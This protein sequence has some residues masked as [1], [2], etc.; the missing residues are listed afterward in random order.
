MAG[1]PS[2]GN[3]STKL[4]RIAKLTKQMPGVA[5][6]TLA[7]H[8]DLEWLHE[9]YRR[10]RKDGA[11]GVDGQTAA[12]YAANLQANL[13]TLLDRAKSGDNYRAPPVRR[14]Y[15]PKGDGDK[16]RPIGMPAFEDKV[17][18]RAI[19]MVLEA[20]YEQQ[21]LDCSYGFRPKRSAHQA[22]R[23]VW[24]QAMDLGG[25]WVLEAD[26]EDFFDSISHDLVERAVAHHTEVPWVRLY[27]ARW[28]RA[29]MQRPDGT[30]E[31]RT[32]GTPQGG[33]VSPL[34]ANLFLH[35]AFDMWMRR[36]FPSVAFERFADDTVVH[37]RSEKQART[38]L[39][40]IRGRF[41]ECGLELHPMKTRI[42]YCKDDDRR[43]EFE[44]VAFDFLGYLPTST[45]EDSLR[46]VLRE[47]SAGDQYQG[48]QEDPRD[49]P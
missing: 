24:K 38:V 16:T 40:A 41:L 48:S 22:L 43:G 1:T 11:V 28:L 30:L 4:E 2:S 23:A 21:F 26:I 34:L 6:T 49:H 46:K 9:A 29:P 7:H 45:R 14:V 31:E 10:T 18:Q 27:V 36:K 39:E 5:L 20:I 37:C 19:A 17:L 35:Y 32:K 44:H 25:C 15:I 12:E 42:V 33:V 8:I 3:V 47:L 13:K